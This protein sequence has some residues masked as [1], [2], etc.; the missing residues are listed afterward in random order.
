[1][2]ESERE[3]VKRE[4]PNTYVVDLSERLDKDPVS[5]IQKCYERER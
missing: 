4:R 1:M 3:I 2:R 5:I